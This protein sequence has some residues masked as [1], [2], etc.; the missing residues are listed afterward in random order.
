MRLFVQDNQG[1]DHLQDHEEE[2]SLGWK[3]LVVERAAMYDQDGEWYAQDGVHDSGVLGHMG[4]EGGGGDHLVQIEQ[5]PHIFFPSEHESV[6]AVA[7]EQLFLRVIQVICSERFVGAEVGG[8]A[9]GVSVPEEQDTETNHG[10][11][12]QGP[13][14]HHVH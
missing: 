2:H 1:K 9:G 10:V 4:G 11:G 6:G 14:G 5:L 8:L 3:E 13:D 7:R 12:K